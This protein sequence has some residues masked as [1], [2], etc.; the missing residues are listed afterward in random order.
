MDFSYI[1]SIIYSFSSFTHCVVLYFLLQLSIS[2]P[3]YP[4]SIKALYHKLFKEFIN[5]IMPNNY[6]EL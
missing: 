4:F 2:A 1:L 5:P 6:E 3:Y